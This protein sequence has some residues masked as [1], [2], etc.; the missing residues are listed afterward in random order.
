VAQTFSFLRARSRSKL[1]L[2]NV[3]RRVWPINPWPN[4]PSPIFCHVRTSP[5]ST[6]LAVNVRLPFQRALGFNS[7]ARFT[8]KPGSAAWGTLRRPGRIT[9]RR[10]SRKVSPASSVILKLYSLLICRI[11]VCE[12]R[13]SSTVDEKSVDI[14]PALCCLVCDI[15]TKFVK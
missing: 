6:S 3:I 12:A 13:I 5:H 9:S 8:P 4:S 2:R 1:A 7:A 15:G 10:R 14:D 11:G